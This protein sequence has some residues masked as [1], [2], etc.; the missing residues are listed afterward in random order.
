MSRVVLGEDDDELTVAT[1]DA[2]PQPVMM[3]CD[4]MQPNPENLRPTDLQIDET[5]KDLGENGQ[6]HN[7][8]VMSKEAF[9]RE[10]PHLAAD[11]TDQPIV[12]INGCRR[13]AGAR[14]A[15]LAGLRYE[16]HDEWTANQIDEAMIRENVHRLDLNPVLLGRKLADMVPRYGS[17]RKLAAALSKQPAW[18]NHRIGL[19]KLHHD[20]QRAVEE[21]RILFKIARE[22]TRLHPDL[23]PRLA[24]GELPADVAQA[25]LVELRLKPDQQMVRW[26][27]GPPF[28]T[29]PDNPDVNF[30]QDGESD[31]SEAR[32]EGAGTPARPRRSPAIVIRIMERS[33]TELA[34]ALRKELSDD[35]VHELVT[36]LGQ[37][38]AAGWKDEP[39]LGRASELVADT[40]HP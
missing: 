35:E 11:L 19:T 3:P 21:D 27:V 37:P 18:V 26:Q 2:A 25:W 10:K 24:S 28:T 16:Q 23:Q 20:L 38:R 4:Q 36:E 31:I 8:N 33:P 9:L 6:L 5:A 22:C 30:G 14:K 32:S 1:A 7:I 15:G 17:E 34:A 13:L 39:A 29:T 12:V 40:Q